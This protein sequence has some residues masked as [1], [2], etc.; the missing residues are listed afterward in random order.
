MWE[1]VATLA[2][3]DAGRPGLLAGL[4]SIQIVYCQTWEYDDAVG[5]ARGTVS[6]PTR[7]IATTPASAARPR[8]SS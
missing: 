2:E 5:A 3:R 4:D 1:H 8:S 7:A 6:A